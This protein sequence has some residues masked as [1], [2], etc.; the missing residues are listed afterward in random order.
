MSEVAM[1]NSSLLVAAAAAADV[2]TKSYATSAGAAGTYEA[3]ATP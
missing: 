1:S 3:A 2:G